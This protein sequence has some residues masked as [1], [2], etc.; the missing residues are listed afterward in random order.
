MPLRE[1]LNVLR[2]PDSVVNL[3]KQENYK[4]FCVLIFFNM[5]FGID[6]CQ[7]TVAVNL[8]LMRLAIDKPL[9]FDKLLLP[10]NIIM[11]QRDQM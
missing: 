2:K 11:S 7:I 9:M 10:L 3:L 8:S 4:F 5:L 6:F 1:N